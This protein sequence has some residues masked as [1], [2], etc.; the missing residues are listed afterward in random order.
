MRLDPGPERATFVSRPN[1]FAALMRHRDREVL[2]H[3][4]NSGRM[5][6]LLR[7][8]NPMFIAPVEASALA[9]RKTRYD[10]ALVQVDRVLVSA[11]A[12]LPNRLVREAIE[13]GRIPA[14]AG[15]DE[16]RPEV[17]LEESRVDL[18]LS[19][20]S[21]PCYV[22][23][24]SVTLVEDDVGLFPDAPTERGRK[25]LL[26]LVEA[27]K[28][29]C[30][31]AVVFVIQRPDARALSPN[32]SADPP[33]LRGA[34]G[35]GGAGRGGVRL[36]VQRLAD[37]DTA[38]GPGARPPVRDGV[39][40]RSLRERLEDIYAK[41]LERY[42]PRS[43]WPGDSWFEMMAGAVL[44]QAAS[45]TNVEMALASL[46]AAGVLSPAAV[47]EIDQEELAR[48]VYSS[49]YYNAKARKLKA[50]AHFLGEMYDDDVEA[51]RAV[52][53]E[54]LREELLG[55]HGIGEETADD[56]LL[57]ALGKPVF[58]VDAFTRRIFFRLGLAPERGPYSRYQS[59]FA[60]GLPTD[61]DLFKE[62]HALI[63]AH[64]GRVCRRTPQCDGCCL[65][66]VCPTGQRETGRGVP[67][68]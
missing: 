7:P 49:G 31:S 45:W 22:E 13:G 61:L 3:V 24:K 32:R 56:I 46:K 51:M 12:R 48:L 39:G 47:R 5:R 25:H 42:G 20:P 68:S 63:V 11:D 18:M 64:G 1:R 44:T 2:V 57:Y 41:L 27:V 17:R 59:I 67:P 36:Q 50:L 66:E 29:G 62:Y 28:R 4:A 6:E 65:L 34:G 37:G 8:E 30:R 16:V 26:S 9:R 38:G 21:E 55:V 15:Y 23:V 53:T 35:G 14:F 43:W 33:V 52:G 60:E 40:W 58:V 19:G 54:T 10:L